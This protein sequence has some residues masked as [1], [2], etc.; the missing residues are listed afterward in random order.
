M[1]DLSVTIDF[2]LRILFNVFLD[3]VDLP[4]FMMAIRNSIILV[5]NPKSIMLKTNLM[6]KS[7]NCL[8]KKM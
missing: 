2:N 8:P 4:L 1:I 6:L 5:E 3:I 7:S